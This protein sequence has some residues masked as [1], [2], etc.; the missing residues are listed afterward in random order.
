VTRT[1]GT[2]TRAAP[3]IGPLF[4]ALVQQRDEDLSVTSRVEAVL[5]AMGRG[6]AAL[7]SVQGITD[8]ARK[9]F[10]RGGWPPAADLRHLAFVS[11]QG[12]SAR[13]I[14]RHG[15]KVARILYYRMSTGSGERQL[16][17]HLTSE[18]LVTD[19]DIVDE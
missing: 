8:G 6:G 4:S 11:A 1:Q 3:R 7:D 9:D 14:E 13:N 12:V 2:N 19:V 5:R 10:W 15:T 17:V 18:G 16:M